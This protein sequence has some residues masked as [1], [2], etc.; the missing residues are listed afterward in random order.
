MTLPNSFLGYLEA[1]KTAVIESRLEVVVGPDL[2]ASPA[3][4]TSQ[5]P[6]CRRHHPAAPLCGREVRVDLCPLLP[7]RRSDNLWELLLPTMWV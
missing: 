2:A 7:L 3:L 6:L 5:W 4:R 1:P